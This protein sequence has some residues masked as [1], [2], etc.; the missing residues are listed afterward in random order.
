MKPKNRSV[1]VIYLFKNGTV[2]LQDTTLKEIIRGVKASK[3]TRHDEW[4]EDDNMFHYNDNPFKIANIKFSPDMST[5]E[6][7]E[8]EEEKGRN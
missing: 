5:V 1:E 8:F 3:I 2:G 6:Y 4:I 7:I